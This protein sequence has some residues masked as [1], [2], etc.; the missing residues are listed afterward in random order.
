MQSRF[1]TPTTYSWGKVE[2]YRL[3]ELA[4]RYDFYILEDDLLSDLYFDAVPDPLNIKSVDQQNRVIYVRGFSKVLL[5][6][7]RLG[8]LIIPPKLQG[9][10][11]QAKQSSDIATDGFLQRAVDLYL[12][13]DYHKNRMEELRRQ[14][15]LLYFQTVRAVEQYLEP[16]GCSFY[17][18]NGGLHLW[19][20]L[21]RGV[22]SAELYTKALER[23]LRIM[24]GEAFNDP[25]HIRLSFACIEPDN[26]EAAINKLAL[27]LQA[28]SI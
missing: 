9:L 14:Y 27:C 13:R 16:L 24:P 23:G 18:C 28:S 11:E 6:G 1:Q 5:P 8:M 12:Q 25:S 26:I 19:L 7:L 4:E 15:Q 10:Y 2:L 22:K 20:G 21:P 3:L 17:R